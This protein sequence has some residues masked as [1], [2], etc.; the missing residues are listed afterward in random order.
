MRVIVTGSR[1]WPRYEAVWQVL[2]IIAAECKDASLTVVHGGCEAGAD[3]AAHGWTV[4]RPCY[5]RAYI[6][7]E[8]HRA[9]WN[10]HG[11]AAGFQRNRRMIKAGAD[12]C[13][14]FL[15]PCAK[16][17]CGK[18]APHTSHGGTDCANR[19]EADGITVWRYTL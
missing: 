8:V 2:D 16:P 18:P 11:K 13:V 5:G 17:Q 4:E 12:L 3:L 10:A 9:G 15:A 19:A 7:E 14:A 6:V 1:N